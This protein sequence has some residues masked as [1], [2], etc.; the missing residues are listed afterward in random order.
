MSSSSPKNK[1]VS[2][3][4]GDII[5]PMDV[6]ELI[7]EHGM[8]LN[9]NKCRS[10]RGVYYRVFVCRKLGDATAYREQLSRVVLGAEKGKVIDHIDRNPMNNSRENLRFCSQAENCRNRSKSAHTK[11]PWKGIHLYKSGY[12]YGEL[13]TL[14]IVY[15][16]GPFKTQEEAARAYDELATWKFGAFAALNFP[17]KN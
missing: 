4:Y 9:V 6:W 5:L 1:I 8:H 7:Q 3:D 13:R 10:T 16:A 15:K 17:E 2:R 11:F 14:G 12:F